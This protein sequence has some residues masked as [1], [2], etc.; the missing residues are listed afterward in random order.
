MWSRETLRVYG[1]TVVAAAEYIRKLRT[2]KILC[3]ISVARIAKCKERFGNCVKVK[4][5]STNVYVSI[6]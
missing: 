1:A 2:V 6:S 3:H 5:K 4:I